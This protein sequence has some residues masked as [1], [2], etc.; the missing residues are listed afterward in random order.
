MKYCKKCKRIHNDSDERCSVCGKELK[1]IVENNTPV[2]LLS[3]SGFEL[4]RVVAAL[5]DSGIPSDTVSNK[6]NYSAEAYT[7]YDSSENNILVPY[8]AY[9]KAYD[10]CVGIGAIKEEGVEVISDDSEN[11]NESAPDEQVEEM[12]GAKRTTIRIV[13]AIM[14]FLLVAIAVFGTDY[15]MKF[16]MGLF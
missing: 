14:F 8:S 4:T 10:V 2:Y 11:N 6:R 1:T 5:E 12:S 9:E 16:I 15:I 13:S 7:G 3:A